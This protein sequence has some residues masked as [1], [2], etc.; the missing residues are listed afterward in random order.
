SSEELVKTFEECKSILNPESLSIVAYDL[1]Y[2]TKNNNYRSMVILISYVPES[3][4]PRH[5]VALASNMSSILESLNIT[6]HFHVDDLNDYSYEY[7]KA[8]CSLVQK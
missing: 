2:Y 5:K 8:Q 4:D 7:F 1:G 6:Q 3:L